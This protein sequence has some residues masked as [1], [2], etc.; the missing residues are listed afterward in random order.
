MQ[1][2]D[3]SQRVRSNF[4]CS[5]EVLT[6]GGGIL[7]LAK[8]QIIIKDS[9]SSNLGDIVVFLAG[10]DLIFGVY[11]RPNTNLYAFLTILQSFLKKFSLYQNVHLAGDFNFHVTQSNNYILRELQTIRKSIAQLVSF[12]TRPF[13]QSP[14]T[15]DHFYTSNEKRCEVFLQETYFSDHLPFVAHIDN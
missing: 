13:G 1:S 7:V 10:T 2:T 4:P 6:K 3:F 14:S 15:I 5:L 8:K 12:V 11:R 9:H